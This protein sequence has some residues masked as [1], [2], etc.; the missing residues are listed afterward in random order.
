MRATMLSLPIFCTSQRSTA[1]RFLMV[2]GESSSASQRAT[3]F[4]HV[5]G[6]QA[7]GA[8]SAEAHLVQLIGDEIE[9]VFPVGLGGIAAIAVMPA[10]LFEVVVQVAHG[11]LL[12]VGTRER[13]RC[14][15]AREALPDGRAPRRAGAR[16]VFLSAGCFVSCACVIPFVR[17]LS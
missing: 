4:S 14:I 7:L 16:T 1:M 5:L 17:A 10:E 8:Q 12:E 11:F 15:H 9:D 2:P 6:L 13:A 3:S